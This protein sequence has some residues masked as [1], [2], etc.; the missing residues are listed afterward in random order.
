MVENSLTML[1]EDFRGICTG[2]TCGQPEE[3]WRFINIFTLTSWTVALLLS[4][5]QKVIDGEKGYHED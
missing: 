1:G 2:Y 4:K 5:M 3:A